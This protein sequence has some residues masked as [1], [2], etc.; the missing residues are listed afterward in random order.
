MELHQMRYFMKVAE[1]EHMTQAANELHVAQPA[2]SK[3]IKMLEEDLGTP[4]F[5]RLGNK[6]RLNQAGQIFLDYA[7]GMLAAEENVKRELDEYR[8]TEMATITI[9]QNL[10][11]ELIYLAIIEFNKIYPSIHFEFTPFTAP[12]GNLPIKHDFVIFASVQ[13]MEEPDCKT[14]LSERIQL[15]IPFNNPLAQR[16]EIALREAKDEN[17]IFTHPFHSVLNDIMLM[18]CELNG[19]SPKKFMMTATRDDVTY[20]LRNGMGATFA[21]ELTWYYM[22]RETGFALIPIAD[23]VCRRHINVRWKTSGYVSKAARLFRDFILDF[24]PQ[25]IAAV[26]KGNGLEE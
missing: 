12:D 18:Q 1:L 15:G 11:F 5:D 8:Q 14:V 26:R 10:S 17:F 21:P 16:K 13:E 4:L 6:I 3:T 24:V 22:M 23:P 19:F 9:S 7:K 25:E 20:I 2:L